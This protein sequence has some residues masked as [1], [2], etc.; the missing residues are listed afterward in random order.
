[1]TR[2]LQL[3]SPDGHLAIEVATAA[4]SHLTIPEGSPTGSCSMAEW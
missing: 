2:T 4:D 3:E 1:M